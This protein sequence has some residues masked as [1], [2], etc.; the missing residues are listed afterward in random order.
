MRA[1][2][3]LQPDYRYEPLCGKVVVDLFW[4]GLCQTSNIEA[5]RVRG[6]CKEFGTA[7][8]LNEYCAEDRDIL[9][10]HQIPRAIFVNGAEIGWGYEAPKDG[11]RTAIQ[12][13]MSEST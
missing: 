7:A 4:N 1:P 5:E 2:Q 12:R 6:V 10:A 11:I 8:L 9:L 3:L 13:A